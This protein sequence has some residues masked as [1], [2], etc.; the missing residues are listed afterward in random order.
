MESYTAFHQSQKQT[1]K[2]IG[3]EEGLKPL[4]AIRCDELISILK[5]KLTDYI[6]SLA[7][8]KLEYLK[9]ALAIATGID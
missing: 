5:V 1:Q 7:E 4:S 9:R 2:S 3:I 6:G 8:N